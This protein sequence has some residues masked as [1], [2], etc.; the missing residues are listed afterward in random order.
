M[1]LAF[2]SKIGRF[3]MRYFMPTMSAGLFNSLLAKKMRGFFWNS[4]LIT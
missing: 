1:A 2:F 3:G 4:K